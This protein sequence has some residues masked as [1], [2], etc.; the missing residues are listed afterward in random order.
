MEMIFDALMAPADDEPDSIYGLV[1]E[2]VA[3][4]EDGNVF[5]FTLRP[6][7]R[8][9]DGSPLTAD[10]VAF[11]LMLLKDEGPPQH[12]AGH[13]ADGGAEALDG[14]TVVGDAVGQ[15]EPLDDP[16]HRGLPIFSKAYYSARD[17]DAS[18]LDPPLGSGP[19]KVGAAQ[20]RQVHRLRAGARLLGR[21]TCRSDAAPTI[22]T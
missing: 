5:T 7:A 13:R 14:R 3:V 22:S 15:A 21:A 18:T 2:S 12:L 10:D 1:A 6:E 19:Y 11:S 4:S 9:H 8:F 17:F 20:R 16:H